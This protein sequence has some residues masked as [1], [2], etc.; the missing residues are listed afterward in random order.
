MPILLEPTDVNSQLGQFGSVLIVSCPVCPAVSMAIA[1]NKP[2]FE[3]FKHGIKTEALED[4]IES[5]RADLASRGIQTDSVTIRMPHP[6][7]CL[8]TARQRKR[9]LKRAAGYEAVLVLGCHSAAMTARDALK[10]TDCKVFLG[11]QEIGLTNA[12][13]KYKPPDQ[14]ELDVHPLPISPFGRTKQQDTAS[15]SN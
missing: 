1:Q 9:L 11:M 4:H 10:E 7:M 2:L 14:V 12:T 13:V 15:E 3:F 6:L 5:I 8:W